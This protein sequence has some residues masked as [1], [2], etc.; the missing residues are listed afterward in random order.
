M[1]P[2]SY[3]KYLCCLRVTVDVDGKVRRDDYRGRPALDLLWDRYPH[4]IGAARAEATCRRLCPLCFKQIVPVGYDRANGKPHKDW[5]TRCLHKG[6]W[7]RLKEDAE[8]EEE[9][10]E[11]EG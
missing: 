10:E 6:C 5:S 9:K 2:N 4:I 3:L 1:V 11:E 7:R 8:E